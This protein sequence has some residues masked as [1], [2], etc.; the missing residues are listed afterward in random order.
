MLRSRLRLVVVSGLLSAAFALLLC[1][2]WL[3]LASRASWLVSLLLLLLTGL[4]TEAS[5]PL[6]LSA[7]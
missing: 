4:A 7:R 5:L 2:L 6:P 1:M 3:L